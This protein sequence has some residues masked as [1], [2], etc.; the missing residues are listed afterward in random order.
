[1]INHFLD[2]LDNASGYDREKMLAVLE[3][4][5]MS[6]EDQENHYLP[7]S[8][9]PKLSTGMRKKSSKTKKKKGSYRRTLSEFRA[10]SDNNNLEKERSQ[11][12]SPIKRTD[13][14]R[15][16]HYLVSPKTGQKEEKA[17]KSSF[18][19]TSFLKEAFS[20]RRRSGRLSRLFGSR[21]KLVDSSLKYLLQSAPQGIVKIWTIAIKGLETTDVSLLVTS[22]TTSLEVTKSV[23]EKLALAVDC[24]CYYLVESHSS[25][26]G[27]VDIFVSDVSAIYFI[28][29]HF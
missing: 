20:F 12:A 11:S 4:L 9:P 16:G 6:S 18:K 13:E 24:N 10:S 21:K 22:T 1:M 17:K 5:K 19:K 25:K 27:K 29:A 28:L 2:A 23:I 26:S 8:P 14:N 3:A 15:I 7:N